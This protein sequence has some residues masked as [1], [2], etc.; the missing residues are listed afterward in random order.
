[1]AISPD[2]PKALDR[3]HHVA[4]AVKD[5]GQSVD[6]YTRNFN[7]RVTYRDDT[8]A[9]IEFGNLRMALVTPTEH[10]PHVGILRQDAEKFGTI[11]THR[12]GVRYVY[13]KDPAGNTVEVVVDK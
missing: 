12:D 3:V 5:L 13:V 4:I 8:W 7:C 6:W 1:M 11:R 2:D 9:M 10:P